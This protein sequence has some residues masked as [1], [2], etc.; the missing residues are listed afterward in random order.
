LKTGEDAAHLKGIRFQEL[1]SATAFVNL[2]FS[3][4]KQVASFSHLLVVSWMNFSFV[5]PT[6]PVAFLEY[7]WYVFWFSFFFILHPF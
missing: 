5:Y 1:G 4:S 7:C 2:F 6:V 3:S